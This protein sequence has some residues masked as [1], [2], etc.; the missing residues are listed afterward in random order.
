MSDKTA[1]ELE[2]ELRAAHEMLALVL[3]E[4]GEPVE[5]SKETMVNGLPEGA[6]IRIDDDLQKDCFIFS[7]VAPREQ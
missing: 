2:V 6:E 1:D 7:L 5:V 3:Y 4:V